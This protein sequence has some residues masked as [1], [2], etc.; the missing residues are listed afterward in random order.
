[1]IMRRSTHGLVLARLAVL[2]V[3]L[4][5]TLACGYVQKPP[6]PNVSPPGTQPASVEPTFEASQLA[7][8]V[9]FRERYGLQSDQ[10]Y[11]LSV[12]RDPSAS[13]ELTVPLLPAE[14]NAVSYRNLAIQ[15]LIPGLA[16][17]GETFPGE[18]A[19]TRQDGPRA[20][21]AFTDR[22]VAHR[23]DLV[24]MFGEDPPI[25]VQSAAH[26]LVDLE[27]LSSLVEADR[28]WFGSAHAQLFNASPDELDNAV[29]VRYLASDK[30]V[31]PAIF[32]HFGNPEWLRL[33]WYGPLEWTGPRGTL[34]GVVV[35]AQGRR[36]Q[37]ACVP[38]ALDL[39]A[40]YQGLPLATRDGICEFHELPATA[41]R[42][43]VF[44]DN[45]KVTSD[46]VAVPPNGAAEVTVVVR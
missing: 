16:K 2:V 9:R 21:I 8:W 33:M 35:D 10:D 7:E 1:M 26:S 15:N 41:Y 18:Y 37:A 43:E 29:R 11:V 45:A 32:A 13:H 44:V 25:D 19:G 31:E 24:A 39:A 4:N 6:A 17:Y 30:S 3:A 22:V 36:V 38:Q 28:A 23:N 14:L 20:V 27:R 40:T 34:R 46:P 5:V 12:A 42:M